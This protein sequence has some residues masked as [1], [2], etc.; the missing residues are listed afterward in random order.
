MIDWLSIVRPRDQLVCSHMTSEPVALL[1]SLGRSPP[2]V[3]FGVTLGV[4][5]T[6]AAN[7]LPAHAKLTTFG[8][9]GSARLLARDRTLNIS[10]TPYSQCEA[11]YL[12]GG[13]V[14]DVVLVSLSRAPDG[15]LYLG[16]SHGYIA[17]AA[18]RARLV[19]AE[20]N[21]RAPCVFGSL[22]PADI[23]IQ[24]AVEVDYALAPNAD[25][26]VDSV[27]TQALIAAQVA[28]LI[29]DGACL[30][31]G[32]GGLPSS[33]LSALQSH[34]HLG[35]HSGAMT[36]AMYDLISRGVIDH[37]RKPADSRRA[38]IG[39]LYGSP[40]LYEFAHLNDQIEMRAPSFTHSVK[41]I[42]KLNDFMAINSAI[43]VDLTGQINA[44]AVLGS[45]G[46]LRYVGGVG[47]LNDMMH[48]A[49]LAP[50]G[51]SI[52]A[53]PSR[54]GGGTAGKPRIVAQLSGPAT[55][56]SAYA[57][58]VVTEHGV[59]RLKGKTPAQRAKQMLS[60]ADPQDHDLL[61]AQARAMGF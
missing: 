53:L 33:L 28:A 59:A 25:E 14:S 9:M 4:P 6:L 51:Q 34:R 47:G 41:T 38:V 37:S 40:K 36:D 13:L 42:A 15:R 8:G 39:S 10:R 52:I 19:I 16:A 60:I 27:T 1:Q 23:A 54:T 32:I 26:P 22:W 43:E 45:N 12:P 17:D 61:A 29:P 44:E 31:V 3:P 5:F 56:C 21:A 57:D 2:N 46:T 49:S 7:D 58:L 35:I 55:V 20:I 30:Q 50:R 11:E 48:A 18:R 24:H